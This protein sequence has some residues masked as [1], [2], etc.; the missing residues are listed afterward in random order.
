M[1]GV[2][3]HRTFGKK[4]TKRKRNKLK[5]FGLGV[6]DKAQRQKP[7]PTIENQR[8]SVANFNVFILIAIISL[9]KDTA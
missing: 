6:R 5:K 3:Y 2:S 9:S 1:H 4:K 8:L 7:V